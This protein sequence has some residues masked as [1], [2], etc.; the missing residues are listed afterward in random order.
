MFGENLM[1]K[2]YFLLV[3]AVLL[4]SLGAVGAASAQAKQFDGV[5]I[6]IVTFTGPQIAEPLQRR[7]PDFTNLT[8]ATVNVVTVPFANLYQTVLTDAATGTNSYD[9]Y[10]FDPQWMPDFVI[11][12]Y[13][14][15][16]TDY[17]NKDSAIQWND[18]GSFFR[19]FSAT[20]DGKIYSI[21]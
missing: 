16:L 18:V 9:A 4:A 6:N 3:I 17:V 1:K 14:Q 13:L 2:I 20:Y 8:G 12:G 19:Q 7:G 5:T 10:V 21:P 15:D 11:P